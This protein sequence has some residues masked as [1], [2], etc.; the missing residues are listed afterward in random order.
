MSHRWTWV[1]DQALTGGVW[2]TGR[3][4]VWLG[5][6]GRM[7]LR[8]ISRSLVGHVRGSIRWQHRT[9]H[10]THVLVTRHLN[11]ALPW[12]LGLR[13]ATLSLL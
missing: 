10:R 2:S 3:A 7:R 12:L 1:G 11:H 9:A 13:N 5:K 6:V 4:S 8:L